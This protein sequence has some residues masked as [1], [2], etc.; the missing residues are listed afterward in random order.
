M[1][2]NIALLH[3]IIIAVILVPASNSAHAMTVGE[4]LA[5]L[6]NY[7]FGCNERK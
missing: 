1:K 4:A 2:Y 3:V 5:N 7:K 6:R